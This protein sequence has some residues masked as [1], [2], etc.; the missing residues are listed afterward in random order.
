MSTFGDK[1]RDKSPFCAFIPR[2]R[3]NLEL[4]KDCWVNEM[5]IRITKIAV[6]LIGCLSQISCFPLGSS[7]GERRTDSEMVENFIRIREDL[8]KLNGDLIPFVENGLKRIDVTWVNPDPLDQIG[9]SEDRLENLRRRMNS[10]SIPRGMSAWHTGI[11]Y[12]TFTSGMATGG[13]SQGYI[14]AET[15]PKNYYKDFPNLRS[16]PYEIGEVKIYP[17]S[18]SFLIYTRIEENWYYFENYDD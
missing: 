15:E 5:K 1:S 4:K 13:E 2:A 17:E 12:L 10:I 14:F 9:I 11:S 3:P 18:G 16:D 8:I 6:L 7:E